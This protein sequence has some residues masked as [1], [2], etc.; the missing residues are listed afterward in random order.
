VKG[1]TLAWPMGKGARLWLLGAAIEESARRRRCSGGLA[2]CCQVADRL[3]AVVM[4]RWR[5]GLHVAEV[6]RPS[7]AMLRAWL[8]RMSMELG[9]R[10][11]LRLWGLGSMGC[12]GPSF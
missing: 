8:Q 2:L 1:L 7:A 4:S 11:G 10:H 12:N 6:A 9:P 3:D 5:R